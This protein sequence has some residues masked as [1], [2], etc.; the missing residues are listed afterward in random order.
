MQC[1]AVQCARSLQ[2]FSCIGASCSGGLGAVASG[3][4]A[5]DGGGHPKI[6]LRSKIQ[7][8]KVEVAELRRQKIEAITLDLNSDFKFKI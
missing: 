1:S 4:Q 2:R 8:S 5:A 3:L 6:Y 7:V